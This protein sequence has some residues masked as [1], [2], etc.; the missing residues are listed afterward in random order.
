MCSACGTSERPLC[1]WVAVLSQR[2]QQGRAEGSV[3]AKG[4]GLKVLI[5]TRL[6]LILSLLERRHL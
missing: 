6:I 4:E 5:V 2:G 3:S 1:A